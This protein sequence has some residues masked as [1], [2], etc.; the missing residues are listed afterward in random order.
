MTCGI[1]KIENLLNHKVYIGQSIH[2]EKRWQ[3]HCQQTTKSLVGKAILKYGKENFSFQILEECKKE[4]LTLREE[5]YIKAYD[6]LVP[7]GYN[8][9]SFSQ[10]KSSIFYN[11]DKE[12]FYNILNDIK[13][14]NL[15]FQQIAE[16][17][18]LCVSMIYYLNRGD[19][20]T[21]NNESYPLR[22]V[23]DFTKKINY[24]CDCGIE[25]SKGAQR[26]VNC[27]DLAHRKS[28]RPS[29]EE[30]KSLIKHKSFVQIGKDYS[31]SDNTIRKWC[32]GYNLPTT[33]TEIKKYTDEDWMK[34]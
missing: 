21:I 26:C 10:G 23:K 31:V 7:N 12:T 33:K 9:E 27:S 18:D 11:Y 3:Q 29:R 20:H 32:K 28:E 25:I 1:Y 16:K 17:Y 34:I 30:L 22:P 4:D 6:S 24:C 13:N 19:Y 8:I 2:I 15:T 5:F 14:T